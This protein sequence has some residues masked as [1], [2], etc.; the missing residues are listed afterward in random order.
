M[1]VAA[2][3]TWV[4]LRVGVLALGSMARPVPEPDPNEFVDEH[5]DGLVARV[6]QRLGG[7]SGLGPADFREVVDVSRKHLIPILEYLDLLGVTV[8]Q[9]HGRA[10][11]AGAKGA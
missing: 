7:R 11:P 6:R 8:R 3:V 4:I 9:E 10:V 2:L 5:V 1:A